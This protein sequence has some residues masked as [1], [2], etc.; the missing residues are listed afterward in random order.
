MKKMNRILTIALYRLKNS[1]H[2]DFHEACITVARAAGFAAAKILALLTSYETAHGNEN[3]LFMK[4]RA[5]EKIAQ[6]NAAD[7]VRDDRYSRLHRLVLV[8]AGSGIEPQDGA[9][10]ALKRLFDMYKLDTRA[11]VNEESGIMTNLGTDLGTTENLARLDAIGGRQLYDGMIE[12]NEDVKTLRIDQGEEESQKVLYALKKARAATDEAYAALM[13]MIESA[14]NFA[15]EPAPYEAFIQKWNGTIKLYLDMLDRKSGSATGGD[16]TGGS[17]ST[18]SGSGDDT[19]G[20]SSTDNGGGDDTSGSGSTDSGSG[21]DTSGGGTSG[22]GS[23]TSD[24]T[25]PTP[26]DDA[27][28]GME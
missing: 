23:D 1:Q 12:A 20:S 25:D 9:A 19:S 21:D 7:R 13:Q 11:Q 6:R 5:S 24:P 26:P 4:A 17:G 3:N 2:F 15:D 22:S 8:W 10:T 18:D 16:D 27:G 28:D 14:A